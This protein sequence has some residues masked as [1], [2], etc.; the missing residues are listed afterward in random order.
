MLVRNQENLAPRS[1][2]PDAVSIRVF[3]EIRSQGAV[4]E[5]RRRRILER[6]FVFSVSLVLQP[7]LTLLLATQL[8]LSDQL[9][10]SIVLMAA[11]APGLNA[12]LFASMYHRAPGASA[13]S[14]LL[15][16]ILSVFSVSAWLLIL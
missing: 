3:A 13:S 5:H 8:G 6:E 4:F 1:T 12:Y 15:S 11:V 7:A 10:R 9:V 14:V 2:G 16:T